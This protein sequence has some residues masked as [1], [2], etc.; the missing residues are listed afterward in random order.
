MKSKKALLICVA[1]MALVIGMMPTYA[2]GYYDWESSVCRYSFLTSG[3][4]TKF[5]EERWNTLTIGAGSITYT[6]ALPS[7]RSIILKAALH[8]MDN[9][10]DYVQLGSQVIVPVVKDTTE[11]VSFNVYD[12]VDVDDYNR[13]KARIYNA[14]GSSYNMAS[15]GSVFCA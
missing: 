7:G 8:G 11:M 10:G 5:E 13:L 4:E 6:P 1:V 14:Y 2:Q 15:Y 3:Y 9:D 12:K